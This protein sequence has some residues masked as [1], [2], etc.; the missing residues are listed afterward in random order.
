MGVGAERLG[1]AKRAPVAQVDIGKAR[2]ARDADVVQDQVSPQAVAVARRVKERVN[3]RQAVIQ[4]VGQADRRQLRRP[5]FA[6]GLLVDI[7]FV[8]P[9]TTPGVTF[10]WMLL[11]I[12]LTLYGAACAV[13]RMAR[14]ELLAVVFPPLILIVS[15]QSAFLTSASHLANRR[16]RVSVVPKVAKS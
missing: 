11:P 7:L 15:G 8:S 2:L 9:L 12:A 16:L 14:N 13:S 4:N 1:V 3:H 6:L 5:G 10:L